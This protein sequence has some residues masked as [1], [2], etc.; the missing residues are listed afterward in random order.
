MCQI[1]VENWREDNEQVVLFYYW[2]LDICES[3]EDLQEMDVSKKFKD[4][5]QLPQDKALLVE[6]LW[7]LDHCLFKVK[8]FTFQICYDTFYQEIRNKILNHFNF[9]PISDLESHC[10]PL[11]Q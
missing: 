5:L 11:Y 9:L 10:I 1:F 4:A 3:H 8:L 6:C 7:L 2:I